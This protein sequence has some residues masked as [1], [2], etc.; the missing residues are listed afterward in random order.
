MKKIVAGVSLAAAL[1]AGGAVYAQAAMHT[2]GVAT[3]A[4]AQAKA[5]EHFAKMDANRDGKID[6]GDRQARHAAMFDRMDAD[7][8]GQVSRAE[9]MAMHT[10]HQGMRGA[11]GDAKPDKAM[12]GH[13][14][15]G[16]SMGMGMGGRGMRGG[17]MMRMADANRD[18]AITRQEFVTTALARFDRGDAN[19]DGKLT[20]E[21]RQS[22]RTAMRNRMHGGAGAA[23]APATAPPPVG[24]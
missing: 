9:F 17:M 16:H 6:A 21:E 12:G 5:E 2:D 14:E 15:G 18:G 1:A 19:R 4:E 3:R 7:K 23:E 24:K 10:M 8:N 11:G 13:H 20:A 22:A